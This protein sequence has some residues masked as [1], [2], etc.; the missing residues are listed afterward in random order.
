MYVQITVDIY[1][2]KKRIVGQAMVCMTVH[3]ELCT[4]LVSGIVSLKA[5]E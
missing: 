2:G 5:K 3:W 4:Y 1:G